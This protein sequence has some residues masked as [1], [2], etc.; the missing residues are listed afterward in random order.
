[1]H[2]VY[3][4]C[5]NAIQTQTLGE[6]TYKHIKSKY[7]L[8]LQICTSVATM[9]L[10]YGPWWPGPKVSWGNRANKCLRCVQR[11]QQ[12]STAQLGCP[13]VWRLLAWE[14]LEWS[15]WG[16]H[17]ILMKNWH[18]H[19][20]LKCIW[21]SSVKLMERQQQFSTLWVRRLSV[22]VPAQG[23][24]WSLCVFRVPPGVCLPLLWLCYKPVWVA[25]PRQISWNQ[26]Q[27]PCNAECS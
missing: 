16:S 10:W 6:K 3:N 27:P 26:V 12:H 17:I 15:F 23:L 13:E 7:K 8:H 25:C 2:Y 22:C 20:P 24:V 19:L 5:S 9:L 21:M 11:Q 4:L 1:M 14:S 18:D